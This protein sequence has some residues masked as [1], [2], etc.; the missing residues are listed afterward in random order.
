MAD[1]LSRDFEVLGFVD[2]RALCRDA[3]RDL[4]V[5]H[6]HK[7]VLALVRILRELNQQFEDFKEERLKYGVRI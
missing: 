6:P 5:K 1:D 2:L 7:D 3:R 4:T